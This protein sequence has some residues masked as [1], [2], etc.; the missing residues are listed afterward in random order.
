MTLSISDVKALMEQKVDEFNRPDFIHDDPILI[1]H[2]FSKKEDIEI[3]GFLAAT[4]AWGQR[5]SIIKNAKHIIQLMDGA[6]FDFIINHKKS[7]LKRTK[8]FVHRTFNAQD[9]N[10]FFSSLQNIYLK[11]GGLESALS[12]TKNVAENISQFKELFFLKAESLRT[13]KHVSDPLKG[14]SAKRINMYL[15]WMVR[16]DNRGVDFGIWNRLSPADLK[17]PL[18]VHTG[19]VSRKLELLQRKQNDWK[20]V[21]EISNRLS[22]FDAI[23]PIKYDFALFGLGAIEGF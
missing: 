17:L 2:E 16:S 7:D 5:K 14:S 4:I 13:L 15:R 22:E 3:A 20:S 18:D 12:Q 8:G 9:L 21:E 10:Q 19:N 1:P 11:H 6:P 23:D